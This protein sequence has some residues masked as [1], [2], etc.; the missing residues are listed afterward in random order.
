MAVPKP[1]GAWVPLEATYLR[2]TPAPPSFSCISMIVGL[3]TVPATCCG[4]WGDPGDGSV[5]VSTW[6]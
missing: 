1:L 4:T 3:S 5:H 6:T 2:Q